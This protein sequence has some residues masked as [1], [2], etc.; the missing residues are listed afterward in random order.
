MNNTDLPKTK[1]KYNRRKPLPKTLNETQDIQQK[2]LLNKKQRFVNHHM[3]Q[4]IIMMNF[5]I[6]KV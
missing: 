6:Q 4:I 5:Q 2:E 1:R 3:N